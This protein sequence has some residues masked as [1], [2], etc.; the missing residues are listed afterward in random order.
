MSGYCGFSKSNNAIDAENEGRFPASVIAQ[1]CGVPTGFI[2]DNAP[3]SEWHHTSL[4]ANATP[5]YDADE[6]GAWLAEPGVQ[7]EL[8]Q[9]KAKRKAEPV[10]YSNVTVEW[11]QWGGTR[12]HPKATVCK[13]S[14]CTVL[15]K[16]GKMV[17]VT[18]PDGSTMRKG[19]QTNGFE[20]RDE[21]GK[22]IS[23]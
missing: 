19:K 3:S 23:L 12:S 10:T 15:D 6:I 16:H 21:N 17:T 4:Y 14:G 11:L 9:W 1:D 13:E 20:V 5:Y 8:A 18:L 22:W 7:E 2:L